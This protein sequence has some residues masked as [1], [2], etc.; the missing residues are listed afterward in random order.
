MRLSG[1]PPFSKGE[2]VGV[3]LAKLTDRRT[4]LY[5]PL[6]KGGRMRLCDPLS[7]FSVFCAL[8]V[9]SRLILAFD[10]L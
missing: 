8:C 9:I 1:S 3:L 4:P 6:E 10:T 7:I 2:S 5:P